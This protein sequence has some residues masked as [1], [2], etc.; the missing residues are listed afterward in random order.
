[1]P[2]HPLAVAIFINLY[3]SC[4][5]I[6][7]RFRFWPWLCPR[8]GET[9]HCFHHGQDVQVSSVGQPYTD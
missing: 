3:L 6:I 1:M 5:C 7:R 4:G 2:T 8:A 9:V